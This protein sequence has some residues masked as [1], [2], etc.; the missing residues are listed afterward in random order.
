LTT[1]FCPVPNTNVP[2]TATSTDSFAV[3]SQAHFLS[4][5][6]V[7]TGHL[8]FQLPSQVTNSP[9][10][11]VV[12]LLKEAHSTFAI[13]MPGY[14]SAHTGGGTVSGTTVTYTAHVGD[15]LD[16]EIVGGGMNTSALLVLG[17]GGLL[18]LGG[19]I[20]IDRSLRQ[21]RTRRMRA[22]EAVI[23]VALTTQLTPVVPS[24]TPA[25]IYDRSR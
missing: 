15:T 11:N 18:L 23:T 1:D 5:T 8:S 22:A 9:D 16:F 21:S 2:T 3:T 17:G 13:T 24:V 19:L 25:E 7:L 6:F 4:T 14:V 20:L 10:P 12:A